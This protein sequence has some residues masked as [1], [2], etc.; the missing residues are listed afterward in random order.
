[1]NTPRPTLARLRTMMGATTLHSPQA[2]AVAEKQVHLF[3]QLS[4]CTQPHQISDAIAALPRFRIELIAELATS[5]NSEWTDNHW[6][7]QIRSTE[8]PVRQRFTLAHE[9]KHIIDDPLVGADHYSNDLSQKQRSHIESVC[10]YFAGCLLVPRPWLKR[11]WAD[12]IQDVDELAK[13]FGVSRPAMIVRLDQTGLRPSS[14]DLSVRDSLRRAFDQRRRTP[15]RY[16]RA[17]RLP[18]HV[19]IGATS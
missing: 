14:A 19:H 6:L 5:G 9:L 18:G 13:I 16:E 17:G 10:D 2:Y 3:L 7:I 12:G 11:A 4:G 8:P 1:M 15:K